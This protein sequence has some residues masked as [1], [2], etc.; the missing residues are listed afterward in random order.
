MLEAAT[1]SASPR[2]SV[3][4]ETDTAHFFQKGFCL[5]LFCAVSKLERWNPESQ[6]RRVGGMLMHGQS[7]WLHVGVRTAAEAAMAA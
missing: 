4:I 1:I 7:D 2:I 5:T 3:D 6:C